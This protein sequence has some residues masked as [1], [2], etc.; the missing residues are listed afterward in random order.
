M[1][2]LQP[3][4][5]PGF[6][7]ITPCSLDPVNASHLVASCLSPFAVLYCGAGGVRGGWDN[8]LAIIPG[9][10]SVPMLPKNVCDTVS[11][12][13]EGHRGWGRADKTER[14][15]GGGSWCGGI[16]YVGD[17]GC[18]K[19]HGVKAQGAGRRNSTRHGRGMLGAD[20]CGAMR[21]SDE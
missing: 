8:L 18:G 4:M 7:N 19:G 21:A 14:V 20:W 10:S 12:G 11:Q 2:P 13:P 6:F 3:W 16:N 9:G 17:T 5:K 15:R 1:A